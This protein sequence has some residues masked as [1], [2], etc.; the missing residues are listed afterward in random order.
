ME[1]SSN[2]NP[3]GQDL[4]QPE[5]I[6]GY[7]DNIRKGLERG[8][9]RKFPGERNHLPRQ[10][11][12]LCSV[13]KPFSKAEPPLIAADRLKS[14]SPRQQENKTVCQNFLF[15]SR[16]RARLLSLSSSYDPLYPK[17]E[18]KPAA[19]PKPMKF[20]PPKFSFVSCCNDS[21]KQS[22]QSRICSDEVKLSETRSAL[23]KEISTELSMSSGGGGV[24]RSSATDADECLVKDTILVDSMPMKNSSMNYP[25]VD[26]SALSGA[27]PKNSLPFS[28][29]DESD[30]K[31]ACI[32]TPSCNKRTSLLP[33]PSPLGECK[34]GS[35]ALGELLVKDTA[36][37][38][39]MTETFGVNNS[40]LTSSAFSSGNN[41]V[42]GKNSL[43]STLTD[44]ADDK[45][46]R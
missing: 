9:K 23:V 24:E 11:D 10:F 37:V 40:C 42:F 33:S 43:S 12:P 29:K 46:T 27:S 6:N 25:C 17:P 19:T 30:N 5:I 32:N 18:P 45:A 14:Y 2:T 34:D 15:E 28:L 39:P 35:L 26:S 22:S 20:D 7:F 36:L 16:L 31:T 8:E 44:E 4:L 13:S 21:I 3:P 41:R 38:C 1:P